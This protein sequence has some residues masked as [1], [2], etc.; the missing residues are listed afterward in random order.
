MALLKTLNTDRLE[1]LINAMENHER[2]AINM[3]QSAE[4]ICGTI[5]CHAGLIWLIK[6]KLP[7]FNKKLKYYNYNY[8][9]LVVANRLS[10]WL[11]FTS[12]NHKNLE[13]WAS[14]NIELWGTTYTSMFSS[15][16]CFISSN[17]TGIITS[18][19]IINRWKECLMLNLVY[20]GFLKRGKK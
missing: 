16:K 20:K 7:Y 18:Q 14:E 1:I 19:D 11:G 10:R 3:L 5:G 17:H 4:P 12:K 9:Y 2:L 6:D 13:R 15:S 8:N